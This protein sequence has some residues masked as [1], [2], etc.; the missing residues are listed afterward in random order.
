[1]AL[2]GFVGR[3]V[4]KHSCLVDSGCLAIFALIWLEEIGSYLLGPR[5]A[6]AP[7]HFHTARWIVLKEP[8]PNGIHQLAQM[9]PTHGYAIGP[10]AKHKRLSLIPKQDGSKTLFIQLMIFA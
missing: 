4:F 1:M 5:L 10:K 6:Q 7:G 3:P 8:M 2:S 9:F